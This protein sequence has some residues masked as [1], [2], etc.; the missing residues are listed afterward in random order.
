MSTP[1]GKAMAEMDLHTFA[2]RMLRLREALPV[3]A[4]NPKP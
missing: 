4:V 2:L 1:E 3:P